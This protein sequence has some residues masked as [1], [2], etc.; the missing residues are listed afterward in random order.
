MERE[1]RITEEASIGT[2]FDNEPSIELDKIVYPTLTKSNVTVNTTML[3]FLLR[4]I[5]LV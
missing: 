3:N 4:K 2:V 1:Q 5:I